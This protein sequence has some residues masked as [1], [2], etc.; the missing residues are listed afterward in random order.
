M[1]DDIVADWRCFRLGMYDTVL[2]GALFPVSNGDEALVNCLLVDG[3]ER[4]AGWFVK[5]G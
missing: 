2:S 3:V 4:K 1:S 5:L